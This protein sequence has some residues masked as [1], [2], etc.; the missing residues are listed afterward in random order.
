MRVR[1]LGPV[2]WQ[3]AG[4]W[5]RVDVLGPLT[6]G[7]QRGAASPVL[8]EH[9]GRVGSLPRPPANTVRKGETNVKIFAG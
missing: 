4:L 2:A 3:G 9:H 6:V 1:V 5:E 8:G 7:V